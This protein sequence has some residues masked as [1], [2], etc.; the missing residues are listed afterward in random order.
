MYRMNGRI[1][2]TNSFAISAPTSNRIF[3]LLF[4]LVSFSPYCSVLLCSTA[5]Q[6]HKIKSKTQRI[7]SLRFELGVRWIFCSFEYVSSFSPRYKRP[8]QMTEGAGFTVGGGR[9]CASSA[10]RLHRRRQRRRAPCFMRRHM[11]L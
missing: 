9:A 7:C 1:Y 4:F 8:R 6:K 10:Q 11:D 2:L 3:K 5:I